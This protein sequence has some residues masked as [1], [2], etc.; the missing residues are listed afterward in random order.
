M[1]IG[2]IGKVN[3]PFVRTKVTA[4]YIRVQW[5]AALNSWLTIAF[6]GADLIVAQDQFPFRGNR[7]DSVIILGHFSFSSSFRGDIAGSALWFLF[8]RLVEWVKPITFV[9]T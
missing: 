7:L 9:Q 4:L 3:E 2:S 8:W 1:V 5:Q 6:R